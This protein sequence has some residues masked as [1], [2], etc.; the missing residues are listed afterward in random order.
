MICTHFWNRFLM[1]LGLCALLAI[2]V[3]AQHTFDGNILYGNLDGPCKE[4]P[5]LE[6][7]ACDLVFEFFTHNDTLDPQLGDPYNMLEPDWV[8]AITSPAV[9]LNDDV[10]EVYIRADDCYDESLGLHPGLTCDTSL[11][12][13]CFRGAL[14][15]AEWGDDWTAGWT[16]YLFDGLNPGGSWRTDID[17]TKPL[18]YL[19]GAQEVDLTLTPDSN[20]VIQGK[21]NMLSGTTLTIEP[22]TV[23]FGQNATDGYLV[24]E[25]GARIHAVG[26][27]HQPII[28]TTDQPPG[29]MARGGWGGLVIHGRAIA[30]CADCL[31]G[32]SC[33]SE[34]GAGEFCG[35]FDC[36]DSGILRYVRVEYAG[37]EISLN[38]ELNAFTFNGV[39]CHTDASYLQSHMGDDDA[40]EWFG[41]KMQSHHLVATGQADDGLDWQMGYRGTIQFAVVQLYDDDGDKGIEGDNNEYDFD[42]H[43]RS[44]PALANITLVGPGADLGGSSR[45]IHLRRGTDAQIYNSIILGFRKAGI[46]VEHAATVARGVH[47]DPGVHCNMNSTPEREA[48]EMVLDVRTSPNPLGNTT[49]FAFDLPRSGLVRIRVFD[50]SGRL[51][52]MV[53]DA[54]MAAGPHSITWGTP[55]GV[56]TGAYF[57]RVESPEGNTTGWLN[58]VK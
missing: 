34:G 11:H 54:E 1:A 18:G 23:L 16:Y 40:F 44:N 43:C 17:Y 53:A 35:D 51:V 50:L 26:T 14:P 24:I 7:D 42:A 5:E 49:R 4:V 6:W 36:D 52:D 57:Y 8:P 41:G 22:G 19:Q 3:S 2:P 45:G 32:E 46:K 20:W 37:I 27:P 33:Q 38:N 30:N 15:P 29:L 48:P 39:G 9:G 25:R 58:I 47:P 56:A 10:V 28:M 12:S 21:V 31:G 55:E 13:C